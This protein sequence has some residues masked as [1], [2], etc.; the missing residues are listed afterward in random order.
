MT[1][2]QKDI[3]LV[4]LLLA[5]T[6]SW[7]NSWVASHEI[8]MMM[9][10]RSRDSSPFTTAQWCLFNANQKKAFEQIVKFYNEHCVWRGCRKCPFHRYWILIIPWL[11][12]LLN[13]QTGCIAFPM[14]IVVVL[15][16]LLNKQMSFLN[17][18]SEF[19]WTKCHLSGPAQLWSDA[20]NNWWPRS[21]YIIWLEL[22]SWCIR[23]KH[24]VLS[25]DPT[26]L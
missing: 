6:S 15:K 25:C 3:A 24:C 11:N 18:K 10:I 9:V 7:T 2:E 26:G 22:W 12:K 5:W 1:R 14:N 16:K 19:V 20:F 23:N 4:S 21:R 8:N 17:Q 13:K